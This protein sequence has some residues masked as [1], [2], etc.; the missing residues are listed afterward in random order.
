MSISLVQALIIALIGYL[1]F[2]TTPWILGTLGGWY[3][4]SRPLVAGMV[5]GLILGDVKTGIII[6]AAIQIVFIALVTPGSAIP[7]NINAA[8]YIGIPLGLVMVKGGGTVAAAVALATAVGAVGTILANAIYAINLF[9]NHQA[10]KAIETADYK[11]L[12]LYNYGGSQLTS[13]LILFIPTFLSLYYGQT[14][15]SAFI[16]MFP[17]DSYVM[18]IFSVLGALLPAA[19]IG[20]LLT[21][22]VS[23]KLQLVFFLVG[24]TLVA[25]VGMNMIGLAIVAVFVVYLYYTLLS[26]HKVGT[27]ADDS[28]FVEAEVNEL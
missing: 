5:V 12:D 2:V 7:A 9:W 19:G 22:V 26:K 10:A 20:I 18:R 13:F 17:P 11:K 27:K 3:V 1:G 16:T 8:S 23:K 25:A 4:L 21:F 6:G 15:A 28:E 24:F 14:M